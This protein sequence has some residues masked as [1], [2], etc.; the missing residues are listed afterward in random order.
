VSTTA[1]PVTSAINITATAADFTAMLGGKW[2]L[3]G[4]VY[5]SFN[6]YSF[7]DTGNVTHYAIVMRGVPKATGNTSGGFVSLWYQ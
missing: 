1:N 6:A 2:Y 5:Y 7:V 4:G 3:V